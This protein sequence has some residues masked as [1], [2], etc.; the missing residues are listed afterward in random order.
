M[1]KTP[2][3]PEDNSELSDRELS[4]LVSGLFKE[5]LDETPVERDEEIVESAAELHDLNA[6]LLEE[7]HKLSD[8]IHGLLARAA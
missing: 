3:I 4:L 1:R 2:E 5:A 6:Q 7:A 8:T